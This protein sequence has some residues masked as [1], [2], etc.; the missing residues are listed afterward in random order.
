MELLNIAFLLVSSDDRL[1]S[2][3][4]LVLILFYLYFVLCYQFLSALLSLLML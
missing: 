1:N 4:A 3:G 2:I